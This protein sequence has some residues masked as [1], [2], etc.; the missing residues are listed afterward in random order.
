M[1][2]LI[3]KYIIVLN[4]LSLQIVVVYDYILRGISGDDVRNISHSGNFVSYTFS[5]NK[6]Y[7]AIFEVY[8]SAGAVNVFNRIFSKMNSSLFMISVRSLQ[9]ATYDVQSLSVV[10]D[11]DDGVRVRGEFISDSQAAGCLLVLVGPS[12]SPDIFRALQRPHLEQGTTV[13]V[14]PSTYTVYGYDIEEDELPNTMPA[15]TL[16][17]Q[18]ITSTGKRCRIT[19]F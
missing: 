12:T 17:S 5:A 18:T 15:V 13:R 1:Y 8:T 19:V 3:N 4:Q 7:S 16:D 10:G 2:V 14:P 9:T 11:G 6:N